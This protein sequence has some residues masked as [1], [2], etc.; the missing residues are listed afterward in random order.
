VKPSLLPSEAA[1][2]LVLANFNLSADILV[3]VVCAADDLAEVHR[4]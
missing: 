3:E 1:V 2:V 4:L